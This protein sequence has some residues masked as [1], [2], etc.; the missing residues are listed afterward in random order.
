MHSNEI[1]RGSVIGSNKY[2]MIGL[3][4]ADYATPLH[5]QKLA[6]TS[7]TSDG[8]SVGIVRSRTEV[9]ELLLLLSLFLFL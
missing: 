1:D 3:M 7:A 4:C 5:P 8:L 9:T 6:L 2:E